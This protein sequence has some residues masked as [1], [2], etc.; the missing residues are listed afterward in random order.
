[1]VYKDDARDI[2][3]WICLKSQALS[4]SSCFFYT[5][6]LKNAILIS[7][8]VYISLHLAVVNVMLYS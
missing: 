4:Y 5:C 7:P 2:R 1:M 6:G 3:R 8:R